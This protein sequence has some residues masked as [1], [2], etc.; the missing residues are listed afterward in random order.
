MEAI[1]EL[2]AEIGGTMLNQP[3]KTQL[4]KFFRNYVDFV[5]PHALLSIANCEFEALHLYIACY[6]LVHQQPD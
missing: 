4:H 1:I 2:K 6:E 3:S 5:Q